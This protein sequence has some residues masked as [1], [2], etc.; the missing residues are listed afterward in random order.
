M[1]AMLCVKESL[2]TPSLHFILA[3]FLSG[4]C[5]VV[6]KSNALLDGGTPGGTLQ[7]FLP[8]GPCQVAQTK[9]F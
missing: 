7:S 2:L 5:L 9:V 1:K 4:L 3:T 6:N 8:P